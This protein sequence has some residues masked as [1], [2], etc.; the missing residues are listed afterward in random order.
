MLREAIRLCDAT[1]GHL[2]TYDGEGFPLA[3]VH[4]KPDL[5]ELHQR[6]FPH[7]VPGPHHPIGRL[8]RGERLIHIADA[9]A[10]EAYDNDPSWPQLV[11]T[12]A[13][14]VLAVALRKDDSLL[15]YINVYREAIGPFSD[16]QIALLQNFAAQ[17]VIAM[18]NA[19]LL[20]ETRE[21]LEQQTATAE[22]LQV[23]NSSPGNL[24]PVF[25][26][27]LEKATR[28]CDAGF[29]ILW[30]YDGERFHAA[31][32]HG[33]PAAFANFLNVPIE[34]ADSAALGD[35]AR[36]RSHVH[37]ADLAAA[38][39]HRDSPLRRATV[40]LGRARTGLAVPLAK[41]DAVL[42]IFV[43]YRQEV[44]PFSDKQIA[45]LQ[46]FAAQAVIAMEN[47][48]LITETREALAQQTATAEVLQAIN[49]SPGDL[50]PVFEAMLDK[51]LSL[52]NASFGD[53]ATF[54]GVGFRSAV[55]RGYHP[56][57]NRPSPASPA[58]R[59][60]VEDGRIIPDRPARPTPPT[61][62]M[63]LY[64]L[65]HGEDIVHIADITDDEVYRSGNPGRRRLADEF[66]ARTAIWVALRKEAELLGCFVIYRQE[67][68]PFT[69]KEIALLQNFAAQAV[70]AIENARLL[71]ELRERT[72][73]LEESLEY[74]TATSDV[75][76]VISRSTFELQPVLDT[77][78]ETAARLCN[79]D[80][81]FIH[82]KEGEF[83]NPAVNW[84]FPPEF[85]K[86]VRA[87][88]KFLP[89]PRT[90]SGRTILEQRIVRIDDYAAD[91]DLAGG[92]GIGE[93]TVRNRGASTPRRRTDW[94]DRARAPTGRAFYRTA[95]RTRAHFR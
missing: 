72:R 39:S 56:A 89:N 80:M 46:N 86:F 87:R 91:P 14:S 10:D 71:G 4:G 19:R 42:G 93:G 92:E 26:A 43:I 69:D 68:R 78:V 41:D 67:V 52:C 53:L 27:M 63:A 64:E 23:I 16:K 45:L 12:G 55:S 38:E 94:G 2:R 7:F 32:L 35:I 18:E 57:P 95:D 60:I 49:S 58:A 84:G 79:A 77:L 22:V 90:L 61:P 24:A 29:G 47:A 37:V 13:R 74:Q 33:V 17:A 75:L 40:E 28:L 48:R 76:K 66:G 1:F 85:E 30:T 50:T 88:G 51:A 20:T 15:G 70:I 21:A 5:V 62:G 3:A 6:R 59:L 25:D 44:R 81:A 54:D 31:A 34:L 9:A 83:Y 82:R 73:D 36:G 65:I 11:A 8:V